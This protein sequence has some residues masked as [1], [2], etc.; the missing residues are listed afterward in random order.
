MLNYY[1]PTTNSTKSYGIHDIR[2]L[3]SGTWVGVDFFGRVVEYDLDDETVDAYSEYAF[4][5][6]A[7]TICDAL[8]HGYVIGWEEFENGDSR[9][10]LSSPCPLEDRGWQDHDDDLDRF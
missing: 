3:A 7:C 9:P 1:T 5:G 8:G 10:L 6:R 2:Q 4:E